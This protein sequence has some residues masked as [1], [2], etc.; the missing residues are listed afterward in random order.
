MPNWTENWLTISGPEDQVKTL[1]AFVEKKEGEEHTV[2]SFD[3][4]IPMPRLLSQVEEGSRL[5]DAL[6]A[7]FGDWERQAAGLSRHGVVGLDSR[8][9]LKKHLVKKDP[10]LER[11]ALLGRFCE[12]QYG[13]RSWY[14][15]CWEHWGTKWDACYP[16]RE[17]RCE[18]EVAYR[19][20][21]AWSAPL[22]VIERLSTM[23]PDLEIEL[24]FRDEDPG[25][26]E[27]EL[28]FRNGKLVKESREVFEMEEEE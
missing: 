26:E 4:I 3:S 19:F 16:E 6:E 8:E 12:R 14:P 2:F 20:Q 18:E 28:V 25:D 10:G 7:W 13:H 27:I 17:D 5:Q 22:P 24:C 21:T 15:W 1:C 9:A 11:L 23:F